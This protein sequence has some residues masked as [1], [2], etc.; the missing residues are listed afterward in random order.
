MKNVMRLLMLVL[1]APLALTGCCISLKTSVRNET[2]KNITITFLRGSN[3]VENITI[4]AASTSLCSGVIPTIPGS[5]PESLII[6]DGQMQYTFAD[7]SAIAMLPRRF[8][9]SSRFTSDFPCKRF[10][11]HVRIA[12]DMTIH[13][14]RVIGYTESEPSPFPLHCTSKEAER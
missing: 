2:G 3:Q 1:I 13:A 8:V 11:T 6:S 12:S 7:V 9:S 4:P 5:P 14:V 10:T